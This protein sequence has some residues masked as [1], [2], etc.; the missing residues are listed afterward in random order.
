[1][2][3]STLKDE[4]LDRAHMVSHVL[5]EHLCAHPFIAAHPDLAETCARIGRD[6]ADLYRA[7]GEAES[8]GLGS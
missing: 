2:P 5:A 1:M 6:L 4:A 8:I 3:V 7:I